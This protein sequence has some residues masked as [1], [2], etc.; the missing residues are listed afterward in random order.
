MSATRGSPGGSGSRGR[1]W[2]RGDEGP[3]CGLRGRDQ[4]LGPAGLDAVGGLWGA[5]GAPGCLG[6]ALAEQGRE[7]V[8]RSMSSTEEA[9]G[10]WAPAGR[11]ARERQDLR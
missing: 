5:G 1:G 4:G 3:Y 6:R 7:V 9:A 8:A 11:F 2:G 10:L